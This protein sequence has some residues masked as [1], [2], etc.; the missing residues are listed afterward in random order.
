M[1]EQPAKEWDE[2]DAKTQ[3]EIKWQADVLAQIRDSK[4]AAPT[5]HGHV[6]MAPT[7]RLAHLPGI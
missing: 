5:R 1:N 4:A 7:G 6:V 3:D 2:M